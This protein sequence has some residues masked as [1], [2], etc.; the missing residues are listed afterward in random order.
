MHQIVPSTQDF[1]A[2]EK[3]GLTSAQLTETQFSS[4]SD[5]DTMDITNELCGLAGISSADADQGKC[6]GQAIFNKPD[7]DRKE[8]EGEDGQEGELDHDMTVSIPY[9]SKNIA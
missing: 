3:P 4:V 7:R 9:L 2:L 8:E 1:K 6:N 5:D